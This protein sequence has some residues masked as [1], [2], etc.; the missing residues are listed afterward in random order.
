MFVRKKKDQLCESNASQKK[1]GGP[2]TATSHNG[3]SGVGFNGIFQEEWHEKVGV[4]DKMMMNFRSV[5]SCISK[6]KWEAHQGAQSKPQ[7]SEGSW[8]RGDGPPRCVVSTPSN[9]ITPNNNLI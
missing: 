7:K 4:E 6:Q 1:L 9:N 3:R 2:S 8:T 5:F